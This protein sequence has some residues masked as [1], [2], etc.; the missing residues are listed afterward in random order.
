MGA[1]REI[2]PRLMSESD[3]DWAIP[4]FEGL[5]EVLAGK[6]LGSYMSGTVV[7]VS[8][9]SVSATLAAPGHVSPLFQLAAP[10]MTW[11]AASCGAAM[12]VLVGAYRTRKGRKSEPLLGGS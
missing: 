12:L 1:C 7:K 11:L 4:R 5:E 8:R 6:V 10:P 9:P 3:C 2:R